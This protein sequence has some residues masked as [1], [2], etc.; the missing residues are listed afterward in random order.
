MK[1][2]LKKVSTP[3]LLAL[4]LL[5][6][7]GCQTPAKPKIDFNSETNFKQL[8]S[9]TLAQGT[10]MQKVDENPIAKM[11]V[12]KVVKR[13]LSEKPL[14]YVEANTNENG[15]EIAQ[16]DIEVKITIKETIHENDS[17]F[18]IGLGTGSA[19]RNHSS[20][21]SVG[22]S[23]PI[24]KVDKLIHIIIDMSHNNVPIWHG[25]DKYESDAKYTP[26]QELQQIELTVKRLLAHY[27][28]QK[29]PQ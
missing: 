20:S 8:T 1:L 4:T 9:F 26:E 19:G 5:T 15:D 18:S 7:S 22:T 29:K 16:A 21:I 12:E 3:L 14:T 28:P 11:K 23:I 25:R 27:P 10:N 13:Q 17:S 24:T 6:V 2:S